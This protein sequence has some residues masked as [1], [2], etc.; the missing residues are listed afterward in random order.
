MEYPSLDKPKAGAIRFNTDSSQMEIYNGFE[1]TGIQ[2]TSPELQT[3]GTRGIFW[4]YG[5]DDD[6]IDF[7]NI[8]TT[9]SATDFGNLGTTRRTGRSTSSRVKGLLA[10]GRTNSSPNYTTEVEVITIASQGNASD[11]GDNLNSAKRA[12]FAVSDGQ[13]GI[14]GGGYT[15]TALN[16]I[17]FTTI[18]AGSNFVDFGDLRYTNSYLADGNSP[19]RGVITCTGPAAELMD[20]ITISTLGNSAA[21]GNM[22]TGRIDATGV[23]NAVRLV[24][25]GGQTVPG[26]TIVNQIDFITISTLGNAAEF[27]DLTNARQ[28]N[29][30]ANSSTRGLSAGGGP[31]TNNNI[32]YLQI[33]STGNAI[34]FGD[35]NDN[36]YEGAGCSNGHGGL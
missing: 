20:Y 4:G 22:V 8:S 9:G 17:E 26:G 31:S 33:M 23:S 7:V 11:F 30:G 6:E 19:V 1:W 32:D 27:G 28:G 35:L 24:M 29:A 25:M 21:F 2:A 34:D 10:G 5:Q 14:F 3:G 15:P 18:A 12:G 13:R 36:S 16:E